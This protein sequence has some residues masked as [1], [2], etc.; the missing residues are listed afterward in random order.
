MFQN[1][2]QYKFIIKL[3]H[4]FLLRCILSTAICKTK[5][6]AQLTRSVSVS[7]TINL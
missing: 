7:A 1:S 2:Q 4:S 6:K 5:I 3:D